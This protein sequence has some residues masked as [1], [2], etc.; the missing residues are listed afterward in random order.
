DKEITPEDRD[1]F[2][3]IQ[4]LWS[5]GN[6][7]S[8]YSSQA[9][10]AEKKLT[11]S[12]VVDKEKGWTVQGWVG[13][14]DEVRGLDEEDNRIVLMAWGKLIQEDLLNDIK[15]GGLFTKYL[16][17]ELR[18]DFLDL[19]SLDDIATSDRQRLKQTDPRYAAL[20]AWVDES[21][22]KPIGNSWR[23]FRNDGAVDDALSNPAVKEW[24][25][26]LASPDDKAAAKKLFGRIGTVLKE[27]E[28]DKR[29]LY[30]NTILAF[31]R[32]RARRA[33]SA[34]DQLSDTADVDDYQRVFG[35]QDDVEMVLYHQIASGRMAILERFIDIAA[36]E[37]EKVAQKYLY[38]HLWLL[39]PSWERPTVNATM[40]QVIEKN[41]KATG[42]KL[43]GDEAKGR[44]DIRVVTTAGQIVII[45]LKKSSVAVNFATLYGQMYKYHDTLVKVL[46]AKLNVPNPS[47]RVVALIGQ[48][49]TDGTRATQEE[50]LRAINGTIMT[51]DE[52]VSNARDVYR[53]Y[54]AASAKASKLNTILARVMEDVDD[55]P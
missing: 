47:I 19:D 16:V 12:G 26:T 35:S 13:T 44:F 42:A 52:L 21:I 6:V 2:K 40:E 46:S 28:E 48:R 3:K 30:A 55:S 9:V 27:K 24:W 34:I 5:V 7:G 51:Y 25:S 43:T 36:K 54:I 17:G 39:D 32:L 37:K 53:E 18:A 1:Y 22:V 29:E 10:N 41:W 33:L 20:K 50:T 49:P 23:D 8:T 14:V 11:L 45:E 4:Y 38:E 15:A 31:E